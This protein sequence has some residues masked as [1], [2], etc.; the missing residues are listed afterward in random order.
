VPPDHLAAE[1]SE[2]DP[3]VDETRASPALV[4]EIALEAKPK[5][6]ISAETDGQEQRLVDWL[7]SQDE[8]S[9]LVER[10][11]DLERR[12]ARGGERPN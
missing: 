5:V 4:I 3:D 10:A 8:L 1:P 6:F 12:C 9:E 11:L 7:S 2:L